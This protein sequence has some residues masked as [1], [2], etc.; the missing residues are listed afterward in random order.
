MSMEDNTDDPETESMDMMETSVNDEGNDSQLEIDPNMIGLQINN[1]ESIG[2]LFESPRVQLDYINTAFE[3]SLSQ[4][5]YDFV[6]NNNNNKAYHYDEHYLPENVYPL[7][8]HHIS[9]AQNK[10]KDL[11]GA[12]KS[13]NHNYTLE[14]FPG[15]GKKCLLLCK[16]KKIVILKSLQRRIIEW[17]HT[18]ICHPGENRTEL[19]IRQHFWWKGLQQDVYDVCKTCANFHR[20]KCYS[21]KY[22]HLPPKEAE[23]QTWDQVTVDLIGPYTIKCDNQPDL[24]LQALTLIDPATGWLEIQ[25]VS[26]KSADIISNLFEQT[27]LVQSPWPQELILEQGTELMAEFAQLIINNYGIKMRSITVRN[28]Q[29]NYIIERCHQMIGNIIPMFQYDKLD[30]NDPWYGILAATMFSMRATVHTTTQAISTQLV[31]DRDEILNTKFE[32]N[33]EYIRDPKQRLTYKKNPHENKK[34]QPYTYSLNDKVLLITIT[35]NKIW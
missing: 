32:A 20:N 6:D 14:S 19:T 33:W 16:N 5:C 11:M 30:E 8:Y 13:N 17:Y 18:M 23:A 2:A 9:L 21:K 31:F 4:Y 26:T 27:C 28:P 35:T 1:D 22:G 10:E 12:V 3:E 29:V 24:Q 34:Q 15:G 7:R 25:E